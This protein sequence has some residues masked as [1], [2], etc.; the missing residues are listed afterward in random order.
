MTV[1]SAKLADSTTEA[2]HRSLRA[3]ASKYR[4]ETM[5][6]SYV[7]GSYKG[8]INVLLILHPEILDSVLVHVRD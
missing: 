4:S 7:I 5:Q 6:D 1:M 3:E 8:I 2:L